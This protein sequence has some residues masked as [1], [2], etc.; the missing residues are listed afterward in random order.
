MTHFE[1]VL[2]LLSLGAVL[3]CAGCGGDGALFSAE[4]DEPAYRE[5]QQLEKQGRTQEALK[6]YL[7]VIA[8]RGDKAPESHLDA[9]LIYL[10]RA[11]NPDPIAAIYH[12]RKYLE[13]EPKSRE[14]PLVKQRIETAELAFARSLPAR[15]LESQGTRPE[16][17]EQL[18]HLKR[19]ND[20]LKAEVATLKAGLSSPPVQASQDSGPPPITAVTPPAAAVLPPPSLA[21][22]PAPGPAGRTHTVAKNDTL[23][24]LAAKYYG[25][26]TGANMRKIVEANRD[27]LPGENAPLRIGMVLRIP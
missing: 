17:E 25:S 18:A 13:Q 23:Y 1:K 20:E 10:Q 8:K 9:G 26:G 4:T 3:A 14:A 24:N 5:A 19:E 21:Q 16:A 12:F 6:A 27:Q 15:P 22:G 2:G 7:R 11:D